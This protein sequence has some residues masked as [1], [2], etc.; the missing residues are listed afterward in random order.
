MSLEAPLRPSM[1]PRDR[2][3][4]RRAIFR[5]LGIELLLLLWRKRQVM[6]ATTAVEL[7]KRYSGALLGQVWVFLNPILFLSTYL[8]VYLLVLKINAQEM[9][10]LQYIL[11]I[12]CGLVPFLAF[13]DVFASAC[14]VIRQNT[15]V[16]RNVILPVEF[17]PL[18]VVFTAA[19]TQLAGL[20]LM[21]VLALLG[22]T[23]S[24]HLLWLPLVIGM[25][26][27]MFAGIALFMAALGVAIP[28][29]GHMS[30]VVSTLLMQVSPIVYT[31]AM[32]PKSI[33]FIVYLNPLASMMEMFRASILMGQW[34]ALPAV[35]L[36]VVSSL[37]SYVL[38]NAA[39]ARFKGT[40]DDHV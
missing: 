20:L 2:Y 26:L 31:I 5:N 1:L 30:G 23:L 18:R 12:F 37:G 22:G 24:W 27:L 21:L 40:I 32:V 7:K 6:Y 39:F 3:P 16:I 14:T 33:Q 25:Q 15:T 19:V 11:Y 29:L 38:G 10:A 34:P 28:D 35:I 4:G 13:A 36:F 9:S 8:F 17:L